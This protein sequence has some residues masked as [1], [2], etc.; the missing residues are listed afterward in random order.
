MDLTREEQA[1]LDGESLDRFRAGA[2]RARG[3]TEER[4]AT[5]APPGDGGATRFASAW[6]FRSRRHGGVPFDGI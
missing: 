2:A 5:D 3:R 1:I 6:R 4:N